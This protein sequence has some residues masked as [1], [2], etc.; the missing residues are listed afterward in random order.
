VVESTLKA[1]LFIAQELQFISRIS[2]GTW[3]RIQEIL[4]IGIDVIRIG[5]RVGIA[6]ATRAMH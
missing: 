4:R 2:G 3:R 1:L 6:A 5:V